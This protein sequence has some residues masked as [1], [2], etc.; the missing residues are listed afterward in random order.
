VKIAQPT[1]E[2]P[3]P[4]VT[5]AQAYYRD[6]FGFRI[7]W[8]HREGGIGAVAHG[9]CA[10]FFRESEP[11]FRPS[12]FWIFVDDVDQAYV[13]LCRRGADIVAPVADTPWGLRQFTVRDLLD[14]RFHFHHDI[15]SQE[16]VSGAD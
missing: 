4:S 14:N 5:A 16:T 7:A 3:V 1:P 8:H 13:E 2:L 12:T 6:T 15:A 10:I 11:P 9:D